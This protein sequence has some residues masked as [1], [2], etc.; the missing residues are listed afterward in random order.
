ML[1]LILTIVAVLILSM[2]GGPPQK[3]YASFALALVALLSV[4]IGW[5]R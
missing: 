1:P 4:V 3:A 5:P 2:P